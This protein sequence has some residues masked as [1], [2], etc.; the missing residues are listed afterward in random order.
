MKDGNI[1][2]DIKTILAGQKDFFD[3]GRSRDVAFRAAQLDTLHSVIRDNQ[4]DIL[5]ALKQDL[6]KSAYEGYLTEVGI[7]LDEIRYVRKHLARWAKPKRVRT[8]L[9]QF[10]GASYIYPEPYGV[11]LI[12]SPWN[13]PL[14]L[15]VGP[16]IGSLAAGNCSVVKPSEF[17]PATA[18][19][20]SEIIGG[21]FDRNFI[22][23]IEGD[24][25]ISKA[26]LDEK[27]DYIFFTGSV[28]IGKVVMA[29]AARNL[30]PVTLE[31]GGKSPC[32]V[33]RD[34]DS[35]TAA[36]RI[37]SGKFINA[38]QTCIAP[39]YLLVHR[40]LKA[41]LM[42]RMK[43]FISQFYGPDP[44]ESPDYPRIINEKHF[45]R[46]EKLMQHGKIIAGGQADRQELYMAPTILDE[47]T[48][49]DP[50]MQQEIFGPILPVLAFDNLAETIPRIKSLPEPLALYLFSNNKQHHEKIIKDIPFG[51]GCIN[52]TLLHFTNPHLPF[53]GTGSSGIGSYH[54][55]RSFDTFSHQK[56]I[57]RKYFRLEA[58]LRYPPYGN[59]LRILRKIMR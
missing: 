12:I 36:R 31:L 11:A 51:G 15:V 42:N 8:H 49:D 23:V 20:F 2:D 26:L 56:S 9:F 17:A 14:Q 50:I 3:S 54:G 21:H 40:S 41:E 25:R 43:T 38:G 27:F 55:K 52:D 39:D 19:I 32:I 6:S 29:A 59:K 46:L 58:P 35:A 18:R 47:V 30:T 10:P 34:A 16:L 7:V 44:R 57:L 53:G 33:D 13:Y 4:Q 24:A 45:L 28:D 37:V 5:N 48:W 1:M 22:A